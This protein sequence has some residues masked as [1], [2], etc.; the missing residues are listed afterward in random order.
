MRP[1]NQPLKPACKK[2]PLSELRWVLGWGWG[3][4]APRRLRTKQEEEAEEDVLN[5]PLSCILLNKPCQTARKSVLDLRSLRLLDC[6]GVL[7]AL[8][9]GTAGAAGLLTTGPSHC[10][11]QMDPSSQGFEEESM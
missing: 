2:K 4:G 5:P 3:G 1:H 9:A 7:V 6:E 11:K 8:A 10:P